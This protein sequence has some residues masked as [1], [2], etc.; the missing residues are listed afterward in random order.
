MD[1]RIYDMKQAQ[2][3]NYNQLLEDKDWHSPYPSIMRDYSIPITS[4]AVSDYLDIVYGR[5]KKLKEDPSTPTVLKD[6]PLVNVQNYPLYETI[7][8]ANPTIINTDD[9]NIT[10][11]ETHYNSIINIMKDGIYSDYVQE[12]MIH[13]I[14]GESGMECNLSIPD[15]Y[16]N[17]I[18]WRS[19]I[20]LGGQVQPYHLFFVDE[21]KAK[22]V[23]KY[24]DEFI[25]E[26][27][28]GTRPIME[29]SNAIADSLQ[30]YHDIDQFSDYLSNTLNLDDTAELMVA[31]EEFY[32]SIHQ[33][34]S[35]YQVDQVNDAIM[36]NAQASIERI[37]QAKSKIGHDHCLVDVWRT[38]EGVNPKQYA[39]VSV[40][41]GIKPD[42]RGGI[43]PKIVDTS[44]IGGGLTDSTDYFI[45]SSTA[46]VAQIEKHKNVSKSGVLARIMNINNTDTYLYPG[47]TYDCGNKNL[48]P[49]E[50]KSSDHLKSL[51]MRYYRMF[52][53]GQEKCINAKRDQHLVGKTIYLRSPIT[54]ISHAYGH[55]IC[56]K[57]YGNLAY[58]VHD[59]AGDFGINIGCIA[60]ELVTSKQTQKQLSAKH[61]LKASVD[62]I[63]WSID[64]YSIF[65]MENTVVR[66]SSDLEN[67]KDYTILI[68]Q[69]SIESDSEYEGGM[70]EDSDE[71]GDSSSGDLDDYITE[72]Y[73]VKKSTGEAFH[74]T[75][76]S[77]EKLFITNELN[78]QIK[79]RSNPTDD[80]VAIPVN[81]V[82]ESP[83]FTIKVR[84]NEINKVLLRLKNLFNRSNEVRG[85]T[86]HELLQDIIDTNIEGDMGVSAVHYEVMLSNQIRDPEDVLIRP[87]WAQVNPPYRILTLD[88]ALTK[89]P[90]VTISLSY[91]KITKQLYT[92][93]TYDKT[94]A[95]YMDLFFMEQPQK[96]IRDLPEKETH[97][98]RAPGELWMPFTQVDTSEKYTTEETT[99]DD[100]GTILDIEE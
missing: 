14:F 23:K 9:I 58:A 72:F 85:R 52:P 90:S 36:K 24:I 18:M 44:Y 40:G 7:A 43:F 16:L 26:P 96:V 95:S 37:K 66:L 22:S 61:I 38:G 31:D 50:I 79:N 46:R 88:E 75:T 73:V 78:R 27:Y 83:L 84:N 20:A 60:S 100:D 42:G 1:K 89:N 11:W 97:K 8:S 54:C 48:I 29:I 62:K 15:Y 65:E 32:N 39:E 92:P 12:Y 77:G 35:N 34:Y 76:D 47:E 51:N 55:G 59:Y 13:I 5:K 70:S 56:R 69:D 4:V 6:N 57:C 64:F 2:K 68:D 81:T 49:I 71:D 80:K 94:G 93:L 86:I 45:D 41:I 63:E 19:F 53:N 67:P 33:S 25:I 99:T 21:L 10:N 82:K 17:L 98:K 3:M 28:I 30:Y 91:Q 87:D 74:I